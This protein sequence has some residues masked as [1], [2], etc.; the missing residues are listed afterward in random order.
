MDLALDEVWH[1]LLEC[2]RREV[3]EQ[4]FRTW[5]EPA[6]PVEVRGN[7]LIVAAPDQFS[8]AWN[9]SKHA[10]LLSSL[11]PLALGEP[12]AVEFIV[13]AQSQQ[14]LQMDLFVPQPSIKTGDAPAAARPLLSARYTFDNFV[15]GK[16][17]DL[18]YAAALAVAEAP[19]RWYNPLF[20]YG[21]SGI[22][23]THLMQAIA[24]AIL[25]RAPATRANYVGAEQFTNEY[26]ASI[27]SRTTH[28]FRRRYRELDLL[29]VDDVHFLKGKE[30][31]QEEF[32]HTFNALYEGGRQIVLTSDR[33]PSDIPGIESRLVTRFQWGMVADIELPDLEHRIAI[34]RKKAQLEYLEQAIPE[35]VLQLIA[36]NVP[37]SVR[38]LEGCIIKL[39]AF[40]SLR[41]QP[42]SIELATEALRDRLAERGGGA[43]AEGSLQRARLS[44]SAIQAAVAHVWGVTATALASKSR[45]REVA[46]P[47]QAAMLLS[48]ELLNAHL[49]EIGSAFGGRDHS[50]VIHSLQRAQYLRKTDKLFADRVNS[51]LLQLPQVAG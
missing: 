16:S 1:R 34:L 38:E 44:I 45:A 22:G 2:A 24:H 7:T 43:N 23:K 36:E 27:Q 4:T 32:F 29:L 46:V 9:E 10:S 49:T 41:H 21:V 17:N 50:T 42:V 13:D 30:A 6:R 3:P 12:C 40:A 14:R 31:T 37:A 20:L 5:L 47:R 39:L 48:R 19:G 8:A 25:K 51:A 33:P 11:A 18:A 15:V 28:D 35:E 26:V